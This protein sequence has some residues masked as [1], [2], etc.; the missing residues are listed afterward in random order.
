MIQRLRPALLKQ[1]GHPDDDRAA[2][3]DMLAEVYFSN[4][5]FLV[6]T[7]PSLEMRKRY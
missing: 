3:I 6:N 2:A 7:R 1:P 4:S 5:I